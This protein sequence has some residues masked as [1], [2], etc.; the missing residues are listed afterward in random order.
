MQPVYFPDALYAVDA[1]TLGTGLDMAC[2]L[3]AAGAIVVLM[4]HRLGRIGLGSLLFSA[5]LLT[6]NL[7]WP[8]FTSHI[9]SQWVTR[10]GKR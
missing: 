9:P 5:G 3:L 10:V 1:K 4:R 6:L 7:N 8:R 2:R